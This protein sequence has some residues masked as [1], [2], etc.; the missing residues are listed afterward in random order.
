M[1]GRAGGSG[2]AAS[3]SELAALRRTLGLDAP[4]AIDLNRT[5]PAALAAHPLIGRRLALRIVRYR[6]SRPIDTPADLFHERLLGADELRALEQVAHGRRPLRPLV[7]GVTV[8]P[9]SLYV[10]ERFTVRVRFLRRTVVPAQIVSVAVRFPS[11]EMRTAHYPL[12]RGEIDRGVV[13]LGGF[14]SGESGEFH[15]VAT[16]RDRAGGAHRQAAT[17]GV[18]TR[19]P[20]QLF[21]TPSYWTKSGNVGAPK[22]DFAQRRWYCYASVRWVNGEPRSVNL[23]RTVSARITD[24]GTEIDRFTFDLSGDIVIPANT[25]V[26]GTW[27]TWHAEGSPAFNVFHAKGDLTFHYSMTGGGFTPTRSQIWRTMRVIGHNIIRVG[28]FTASERNE[29]RRASEQVASGIFRARDMTV[30]GVELY[31]IEGTPQ[32][33]ADKAR[34]R[35][36]DGVAEFDALVSGYTVGNWF[37]DVFFVETVWDGSFGMSRVNGPVDKQGTSSG[38][39]IRRDGDTVNLGQTFAHESGHY[40]GLEHAD[41]NDGC[42]DTDPA[43]PNISDNFIF[44]SS[45]SD[46]VAITLCQIDKMRRHGLVHSLTP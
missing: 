16:L 33:D 43:D 6:R 36:L 25:T 15:V 35:F 23:G 9:A 4:P 40:L 19:N 38:I 29:Y 8:S 1:A 3:R 10:G 24:A 2:R 22:F 46:S 41:E 44:S 42:T 26:Y 39:V 14:V 17:F 45:R 37:L 13:D 31:R 12:T 18:F 28:D 27:Y 5:T 11:G 32:M 21:V 20:V 34:F 7:T 30:Y